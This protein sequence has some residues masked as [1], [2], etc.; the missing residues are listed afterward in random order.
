MKE[1]PDLPG[2]FETCDLV[3]HAL[4]NLEKEIVNVVILYAMAQDMSIVSVCITGA[5]DSWKSV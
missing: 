3:L 4:L 5:L 1:H 2:L